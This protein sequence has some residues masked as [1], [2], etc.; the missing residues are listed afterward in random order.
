ML[1]GPNRSKK[2]FH[3]KS[4]RLQLWQ[5]KNFDDGKKQQETE[6][7]KCLMEVGQE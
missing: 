1:Q 7:Y 2:L 3:R 6:E 4:V 5:F